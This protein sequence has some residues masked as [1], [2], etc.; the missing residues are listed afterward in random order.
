MKFI[1]IIIIL[2]LNN[3]CAINIMPSHAKSTD[4]DLH[5]LLTINKCIINKR[6]IGIQNYNNM[7]PVGIQNYNNFVTQ[8]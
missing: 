4:S 5:H 7:L 1:R 3:K 8:Q 2:H 6:L